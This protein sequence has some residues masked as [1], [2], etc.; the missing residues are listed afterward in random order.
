MR[1]LV[2]FLILLMVFISPLFAFEPDAMKIETVNLEISKIKSE[3]E[4]L[5]DRKMK[6]PAKAA[7]Y[8]GLL[9]EHRIKLEKLEQELINLQS[10]PEISVPVEIIPATPEVEEVKKEEPSVGQKLPF[11]I[12]GNFGALAGAT[13]VNAEARF[14][15]PYVLKAANS[16]SRISLGYAFGQDDARKYV[17]FCADIM[18]NLPPGK[19]TGM[20][21]YLGVGLNYVVITSGRVAGTIG[22]QMF[23]GVEA[24][25]FGG[26]LFGELGYGILRTGFSS[27]HKGVTL[28]IGFRKS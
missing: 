6:Y 24:E 26:K 12:G 5:E 13:C 7:V 15:L 19:I 16:S 2:L 21:N 11:E 10:P 23:Y 14:D 9:E 17:P 20:D 28:L 22:G 25:G 8:D 27:S 18:L 1:K 4:R 3:M